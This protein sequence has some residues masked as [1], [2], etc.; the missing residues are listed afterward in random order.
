[1]NVKELEVAVEEMAELKADRGSDDFY[2][3]Y[4][5]IIWENIN[6]PEYKEL[7]KRFFYPY[8]G[9]GNL[10]RR[11][12]F[13]EVS[14]IWLSK[15]KPARDTAI[16]RMAYGKCVDVSNK[17]LLTQ[18]QSNTTIDWHGFTVKRGNYY[19]YFKVNGVAYPVFWSGWIAENEIYL[20]FC[21]T[22][23]DG[24]TM[25]PKKG[26]FV[27]GI[28]DSWH[29]LMSETF[30]ERYDEAYME[31]AKEQAR[32]VRK[33][34]IAGYEDDEIGYVYYEPDEKSFIP[35]F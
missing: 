8:L 5:R 9:S 33:M 28:F 21:E 4:L 2:I 22:V 31:W 23:P 3:E 19:G 14:G 26:R 1:M 30:R 16:D 13:N 27:S 35:H 25:Q 10:Y 20:Y 24:C 7:L 17:L 15:W 12:L 11:T 34:R 29:I 32:Y 6:N 18:H